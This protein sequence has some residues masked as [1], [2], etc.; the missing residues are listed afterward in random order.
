MQTK[1]L[2]AVALLTGLTTAC[3]EDITADDTSAFQYLAHG[4]SAQSDD[5]TIRVISSQHA[6][7]QVFYQLLNRGGTPETI[8]FSQYQVLLVMSGAQ[9]PATKLEVSMFEQQASAVQIK[10]NTQYPG[11]NC[12]TPTVVS[13][14]WVLV[15]FPRVEKPLSVQEQ[16]AIVSC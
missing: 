10:L 13:Q 16:V 14:P 6:Y 9:T 3:V 7:D 11:P 8:D 12:A 4:N 2:L 5:K 15:L 1:M